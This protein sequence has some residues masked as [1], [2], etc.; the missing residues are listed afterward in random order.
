MLGL[1]RSGRLQGRVVR[2]QAAEAG[3]AHVKPVPA[4]VPAPAPSEEA[5]GPSTPEPSEELQSPARAPAPVARPALPAPFAAAQPPRPA[6]SAPPPDCSSADLVCGRLNEQYF[7]KD[8]KHGRGLFLLRG[9][10]QGAYIARY[11]G[12]RRT[13]STLPPAEQLPRTH[14]LRV[15]GSDDVL[16]GRP[17]ADGLVK[18]KGSKQWTPSNPE[19]AD[20][21]YASLANSVASEAK[22]NARIV[23]LPDDTAPGV[24]K[25]DYD[26]AAAPQRLN[27]ALAELLPRGAYLVA[28]RDIAPFEEVVWRYQFVRD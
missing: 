11:S 7:V 19:D 14:M 21:G 18:L 16:D 28:K 26:A 15:R 9:A 25:P 20:Q 17:L 13:T 8:S 4:P 27:R 23:F 1:D 12:V 10:K 3:K 2:K 5:C 22:A 24:R 6:P